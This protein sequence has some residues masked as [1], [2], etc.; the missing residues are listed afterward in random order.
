MGCNPLRI[1]PMPLA[2]R[3]NTYL[4]QGFYTPP[5]GGI[6]QRLR[7]SGPRAGKPDI[8]RGLAAG[9]YSSKAWMKSRIRG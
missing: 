5:P 9:G 2:F 7:L 6:L 3:R 8:P 1:G 4:F